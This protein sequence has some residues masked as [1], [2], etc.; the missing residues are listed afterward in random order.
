MSNLHPH[1]SNEDEIF[2]RYLDRAIVQIN[3]LTKQIESC[4]LCTHA[5]PFQPV[6]GT[7][8]PLAEIF[9][10]KY[11]PSPAEHDEGVAFYG[12]AGEAILKSMRRLN[13]DPL[14]LYGTNCLKCPLDDP[15]SCVVERCPSWLVEELQIVQP[16]LMVV[17]G[18]DARRAINGLRV[19]DSEPIN[20]EPGVIA[21]W[22]ATCDVLVCPDI[23]DSLD[24]PARKQEFWNAFRAIGPWY[25]E[26]P[27]Y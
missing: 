23:D 19:P 2:Q 18:D 26:L 9:L 7:G 1:R 4:D 21:K 13:V 27:P 15:P 16:R 24:N 14:S 5:H 8:H 12:R 6:V 10:V 22:S 3:D 11:A 17:M 25:D 20:D